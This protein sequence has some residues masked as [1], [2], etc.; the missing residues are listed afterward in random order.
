MRAL[1]AIAL[2]GLLQQPQRDA[3]P[4]PPV[5]A[6]RGV[7]KGRVVTADSGTPIRRAVVMIAAQG[8]PPRTI[9]TDG[10][11]RYE[12][13]NL[14]AASYRVSVRPSA[15]QA[16]YLQPQG[17][18]PVAPV[19]LADGQVIEWYDLTLRRAGAIVGRIV[20]QFGE[21]VAGVQAQ[22]LRI[23]SA[24]NDSWSSQSSDEFGRFRIYRLEPGEYHV[25]AKPSAMQV[26]RLASERSIGFVETYYPS[27]LSRADAMRV[28]V[29]AGQETS[30]TELQ[31]VSSRMMRIAGV[32]VNGRTG[33]SGLTMVDL[34]TPGGGGQ[35]RSIDAD[36]RF[37]FDAL[38][39]GSYTLR[40]RGLSENREALLGYAMMPL[41]LTDTDVED[42]AITLKPTVTLSGRLVYEEAGLPPASSGLTI[43]ADRPQRDS[44]SFMIPT[45]PVAE[46]L[47]FTLRNL[48]GELLLRPTGNTSGTWSLKAVLL[49]SED[50]TDVPREFRPEDSGRIQIVLT[51][52]WAQLSGKVVGDKG[53]PVN[54]RTAVLFPEDSVLWFAESSRMRA[55]FIQ[56]GTFEMRGLRPGK[57]YVAV[58]PPDVRWDFQQMDKALLEKLAPDATPV[59]IGEDDRREVILR[60]PGGG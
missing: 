19:A 7:I 21:P 20:D 56:K 23:G 11:G 60:A 17:G 46:D 39:P 48:A 36:G 2:V 6:G 10:E 44:T 24:T 42:L 57:Y 1:L 52:R 16:Q 27:T 53:E 50:I 43:R 4:A 49:G 18:P 37:S 55:A 59:V 13:R 58:L 32:V 45:A 34:S 26:E 51:S 22:T 28:T 9:Y 5:I 3:A 38:P 35:G 15:G 47:S 8:V 40:V 14:P 25:I 54:G 30:I 33:A 31:L 12:A 29:R 41:T